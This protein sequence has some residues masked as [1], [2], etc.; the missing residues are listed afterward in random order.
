MGCLLLASHIHHRPTGIMVMR[1]AAVAVTAGREFD[2]VLL[3][4]RHANAGICVA[5]I[6]ASDAE[7]YCPKLKR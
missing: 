6:R 2:S 7:R 5:S 4:G 3:T 1:R